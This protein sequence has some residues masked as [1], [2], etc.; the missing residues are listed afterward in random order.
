MAAPVRQ[1][2]DKSMSE[3][4]YDCQILYGRQLKQPQLVGWIGSAMPF[5]RTRSQNS[6]ACR[7]SSQICTPPPIPHPNL[8]RSLPHG[9]LQA[10]NVPALMSAGV[11][12]IISVGVGIQLWFPGQM[13]RLIV[14]VDDTTSD[15]LL[16]HLDT[17]CSFIADSMLVSNPMRCPL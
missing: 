1:R 11:T 15:D 14:D 12:H 9:A 6:N 16:P 7:E 13:R 10:R 2:H 3:I 8:P 4:W 17:C 5:L